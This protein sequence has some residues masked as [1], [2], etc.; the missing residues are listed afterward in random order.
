M[1]S[2][3]GSLPESRGTPKPQIVPG[4]GAFNRPMT[5]ATL[6]SALLVLCPAIAAA[7]ETPVA[8]DAQPAPEPAP[9]PAVEPTADVETTPPPTVTEDS[10]RLE[11]M[12]MTIGGSMGSAR[13]AASSWL[14]LPKGW[15]AS[16]EL[17]FLTSDAP[18]GGEPTR[19]TDVVVSRATMRKSF[20]G[21]V[22]LTAGIDVL[23]KQSSQTDELILQGADLNARIGFATKYAAYVGLGGGPLTADT[24]WYATTGAGIQRRAI[25]HDTLSFQLGLGG[26]M[27]SMAF[28][29]GSASSAWL[30]EVV[31]R[32]QTLF[33]GEGMFGVYLGADFGF[34]V[35]HGGTLMSGGFDPEPRVDV[36]IGAVYSVVEDWDVYLD[37]SIIDR[38]E[39]GDPDTQLPILQG[40][41]D[42][43]V[44]TFGITRH[45]GQRDVPDDDMYLAY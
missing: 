43:T 6:V 26:S 14:I 23:P 27:T 15:E 13:S 29:E 22:E 12:A 5:R 32:G 20:K 16:G 11:G 44:F 18:P 17:R 24:G 34:P 2:I 25:V 9:E 7:D 36:G 35:V 21:R 4:V 31:V 1:C 39:L 41:S 8:S 45:F 3:S 28:D 30:G 19:M 40:G 38:G 10:Y 42:Q 33:R 37:A